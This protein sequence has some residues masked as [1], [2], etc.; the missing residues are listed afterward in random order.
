MTTLFAIRRGLL[1]VCLVPLAA[2]GGSGD[3]SEPNPGLGFSGMYNV[4][5]VQ[6]EANGKPFDG[7]ANKQTFEWQVQSVCESSDSDCAVIAS[8]TSPNPESTL[9]A[10]RVDLIYHE[11]KWTRIGPR[12]TQE[13]HFSGTGEL[14]D[15]PDAGIATLDLTSTEQADGVVH[16]LSGSGEVIR[17]GSCGGT[18]RSDFTLT[19]IGDLPADTAEP[20]NVAPIADVVIDPPGSAFRGRYSVVYTLTD[21]NGQPPPSGI[22][23]ALIQARVEQLCTRTGDLCLA[24]L[25]SDGANEIRGWLYQDGKFAEW[26]VS[27]QTACPTDPAAQTVLRVRTELTNASAANPAQL[28]NGTQTRTAV[29]GNCESVQTFD[30]VATR[31]GE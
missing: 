21:D 13:C 8:G 12:K 26:Y 23:P 17:A 31:I 14:I 29:A 2:C 28:L 18:G 1:V 22:N 15:E 24:A 6:T 19:R 25:A 3:D 9:N 30:V 16:K 20:E 4:E 11:G 27:A 10:E 7:S 5:I